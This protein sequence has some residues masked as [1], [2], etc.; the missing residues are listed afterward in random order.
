[1]A[2]GLTGG[3]GSG[4]STVAGM[5]VERGAVLIDSD[6]LAREAVEPG[7]KAWEQVCQRFGAEVVTPEGPIDRAALARIVFADA[8]ARADLD[9]IVHPVVGTEMLGRLA[10]LAATDHVVVLDVPL[11]AEKGRQHYPVAG[12]IVVDCPVELAIERLVSQRA[13]R[14]EDAQA[15]VAAQLSREDRLRQADFVILNVGNLAELREMVDRAW[16]WIGQLGG[17]L[18]SP[19]VDVEPPDR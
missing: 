13:M 7:T 4:K 5:L 14:R 11:L 2:I 19:P 15:R 17:G 6:V 12:V 8:A 18:V 16:D 10:K 1:M 9:A 3:I